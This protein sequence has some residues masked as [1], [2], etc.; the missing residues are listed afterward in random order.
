MEKRDIAESRMMITFDL[1]QEKLKVYYPKGNSQS[2]TFYKK[3]Y[4]DIKKFMLKNGFLHRQYS[5]Y[6]SNDELSKQD[7]NMICDSI[8]RK[9]PWIG[10]C[11]NELDI[12]FVGNEYSLKERI[13]HSCNEAQ[14]DISADKVRQNSINISFFS[15]VEEEWED[16]LEP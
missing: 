11:I 5:V 14:S 4:G 12:T 8:G 13:I 9:L 10:E 16:E 1:N 3:A 7:V 6:I 2:E 15:G